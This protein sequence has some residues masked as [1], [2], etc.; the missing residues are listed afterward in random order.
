MRG[1]RG[2]RRFRMNLSQPLTRP[3]FGGHPLPRRGEGSKLDQITFSSASAPEISALDGVSS[4]LSTRT[5][6]SST[7]M[8]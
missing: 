7:S 6:P 3:P 8:A 2:E 5:T 4:M 1:G